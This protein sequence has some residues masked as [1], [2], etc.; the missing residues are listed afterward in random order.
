MSEV[1]DSPTTL[2]CVNHPQVETSLRCNRCERP[3]CTKCA[4]LT[5]TGYRCKDCVR[6][7]Q[8][9]YDTAQSIDY[10]LAFVVAAFISFLGSLVSSVMGFFTI[11]LAPIAGVIVAEA[12]R[13]VIHR[14]RSRLLFQVATIGAATG[15]LFVVVREILRIFLIYSGGGLGASLIGLLPLLWPCIYTFIV[16]STVYYR[17]AGIRLG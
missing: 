13:G 12:V 8:K 11:F 5:P 6:G 9:T 10:P 14:R 16:S 17:L 4:V 7:I 3:I 15:S 2:H 1:Y